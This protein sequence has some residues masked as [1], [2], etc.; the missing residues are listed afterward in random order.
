[1]LP[2]HAAPPRG[3]AATGF[4]AGCWPGA[5]TGLGEAVAGRTGAGLTGAGAGWADADDERIKPAAMLAIAVR[6]PDEGV[7]IN[8]TGSRGEG[9]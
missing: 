7:S 6:I 9:P 5:A 1:M 8:V 4:T 2:C 3:A